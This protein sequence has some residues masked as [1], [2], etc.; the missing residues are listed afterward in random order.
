[1][2]IFFDF[3]LFK[4]NKSLILQSLKTRA[5]FFKVFKTLKSRSSS[6]G[7]AADL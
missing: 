3:F 4:S 2:E 6:A 7:R 1:M 5:L